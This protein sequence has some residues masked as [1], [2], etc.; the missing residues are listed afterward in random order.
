MR[1][2]S[3]L[4]REAPGFSPGF[5]FARSPSACVGVFAFTLASAHGPKTGTL[6][7]SDSRTFSVLDAVGG[8]ISL[9]SHA[10][11]PVVLSLADCSQA[12][13]IANITLENHSLTAPFR[14]RFNEEMSKEEQL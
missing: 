6:G 10:T 13:I 4:C 8:Q 11:L 2:I 3:G 1:V 9:L 5:G 14:P 7:G 12:A